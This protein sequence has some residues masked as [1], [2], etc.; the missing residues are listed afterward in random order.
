MPGP[1]GPP[2]TGFMFESLPVS[3]SWVAG[4]QDDLVRAH[5]PLVHAAV[6]T[7]GR[8]VPRHICRDDLLGAALLGLVQAARVWDPARGVPFDRFASTR[9]KGALLD[10]LRR[11]DWASR[12][13]RRFARRAD[14]AKEALTARLGRSPTPAEVASELG[15]APGTVT[16][17]V[18][19]RNRAQILHLDVLVGDRQGDHDLPV[20]DAGPE[21][22]LIATEALECLRTAV[23][24]LPDRLRYIVEAS[25]LQE[26]NL[27][28][29]A[30]ELGV[31]ES[32]I[33]QLRT[34]A[35]S[36]LRLAMETLLG[37]ED[38][39]RAPTSPRQDAYL[40]TVL[41]AAGKPLRHAA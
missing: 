10:E 22:A 12:S 31:T 28:T 9:V 33:S 8:R 32:R 34:E 7:V 20:G 40:Q 3:G 24:C 18:A 19:D 5:L 38:T 13:V 17:N 1:W 30:V 35:V 26:G 21:E 15:E 4:D 11:D 41:K 29:P 36:L 37:A 2:D 27:R 25:F 39:P 16:A 14:A 6:A 23:A